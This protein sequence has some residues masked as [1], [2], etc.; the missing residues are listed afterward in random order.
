MKNVI[1]DNKV[2]FFVFSTSLFLIIMLSSLVII[3]DELVIDKMV[4]SFLVTNFSCDVIDIFMI[5]IT[6]LGNTEFVML[7]TSI[8]FLVMLIA[9][10]KKTISLSFVFSVMGI[11]F[12]NQLLKFTVKRIRP[13]VNRLI[14]IGGYSFPSGHAMVST[15]LYGLLSYIAYKFIKTKCLRNFIIF[16]NVL[17]ILLIGISRIYLGVH[18][19]SDIMVGWLVSVLFLII[20]INYLEKKVFSQN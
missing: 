11:A 1:K 19:F 10:D 5:N 12:I 9:L 3:Y 6:K 20:V 13:N 7:F 2:S 14:E 15:V 8:M 17:L 18:Y 16:V 4:Y